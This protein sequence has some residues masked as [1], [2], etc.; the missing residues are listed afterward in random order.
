MKIALIAM[1][2]VRAV[3]PELLALGMTLPG[4][5]ERGKTIAMLPSLGLLTLAALTPDRH[6]VEYIEV[7]DIR[8]LDALPG[9]FDLVAISS[10]TAQMSEGY[11]LADRYRQAGVRVVLGGLHVTAMPDEAAE[12]ADAVVVGEGEPVWPTLLDDAERGELKPRYDAPTYTFDNPPIPAY[13]MLDIERYNRL[14]VQTSR[15]CPWFCEFC[16]SSV[17]LAPKYKQK[18]VEQVLAEIDRICEIWQRPFIEFADDNAFV[19]HKYWKHLLPE[20]ERRHI[21][22]FAETDL[23]VHRDPELLRMMRD[24]GCAEVL[25]G[26][27]SPSD[28]GLEGLELRSDWKRKHYGESIRAVEVIQSHGIRVNG[29]FILGLDGQRPEVFDQ[30]E[31][32]ANETG[33]YDVQI[34]LQTPFPGTPLYDRLRK[35]DRMLFDGDWGRYTLFD[36]THTPQ[37]MSTEELRVGFRELGKRIYSAEATDQRREQF[38]EQRR[39][40]GSK[41]RGS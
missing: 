33:L 12:H 24:S 13:E 37:L 7:P 23:S 6:E 20:L 38:R 25:I 26:F 9:P 35:E 5:V 18:R 19:D 27:E 3:D 39:V 28:I 17:L 2:G 16:A 21:R 36:I 10:F 14:T 8:D 34:T 32:F 11:D 4:F 22:W 40:A 30:V 15:G 1:S 29:C 31:R 41:R